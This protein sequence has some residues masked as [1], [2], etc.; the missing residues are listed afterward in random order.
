MQRTKYVIHIR[1]YIVLE[2]LGDYR[3]A[4]KIMRKMDV[5]E[6]QHLSSHREKIDVLIK[7]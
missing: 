3:V 5:Q 7:G 4:K 2:T 6:H 1:A